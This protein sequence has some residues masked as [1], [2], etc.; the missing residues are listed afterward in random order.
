MVTQAATNAYSG[1]GNGKMTYVQFVDGNFIEAIPAS[2]L[3]SNGT[4]CMWPP[5]RFPSRAIRSNEAAV[6][7]WESFGVKVLYKTG[8]FT[9][10]HFYYFIL[11]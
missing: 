5:H 7:S 2:W 4:M 6:D 10:Y 1:V 8:W 3:R 9:I 11:S